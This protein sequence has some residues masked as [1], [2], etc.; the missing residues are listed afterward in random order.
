MKILLDENFP[1]PLYRRLKAAGHDVE[2]LIVL[3]QCGLPD[4]AIRHHLQ[5]EDVLFLTQ[6]VEFADYLKE[7]RASIIISRVPQGLPISRRVE[8]WLGAI[9]KFLARRPAGKLFDLLE[10][11]Q[12]IPWEVREI[13]R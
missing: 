6:D 7:Y 10:T 12:L 3:G 8:I 2:H 13:E 1:L 11:G 9:E 4:S 5:A